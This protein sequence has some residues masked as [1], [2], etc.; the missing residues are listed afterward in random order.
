MKRRNNEE[1]L[2]ELK[3][4]NPNIVTLEI[5]KNSSTKILFKCLICNHE[6]KTIPYSVL[7]GHGC[8]ICGR[9]T[10]NAKMR[11]SNN[12]FITEL[13]EKLPTVIPCEEYKSALS[14]IKCKCGVCGHEWMS[15]PNWLLAGHGCPICGHAA[16]GEKIRSNNDEFRK[17][18]ADI[19][20]HITPLE[21]Y[22]LSSKPIKYK[23]Q[24]CGYEWKA[25]PNNILRGSGCPKCNRIFQT[26]FPEQAVYYYVKKE[27]D[28]AINGYKLSTAE[29]D[30]YIPSIR[31]GIEYDGRHWHKGE[32]ALEK[33]KKSM[34][35]YLKTIFNSFVSRKS[36]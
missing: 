33:E 17:K 2:S 27:F 23:C 14:Y 34:L 11:K 13:S 3:A 9:E 31:I 15:K 29:I 30:I 26:S 5:Y 24:V 28:D 21:E 8:P 1:F 22:V 25:T 16:G 4:V 19:N 6:W 35:Y 36:Q 10:A 12:A 7:H 20:A 32:H 18:L